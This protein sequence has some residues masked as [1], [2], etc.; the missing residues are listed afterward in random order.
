MASSTHVY[1]RF[2]NLSQIFAVA[3]YVRRDREPRGWRG[4][5]LGQGN[6]KRLGLLGTG[7][8][9]NRSSS[10]SIRHSEGATIATSIFIADGL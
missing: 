9:S 5:V 10:G 4:P 8:I 7:G 3:A 1:D 2:G 6:L